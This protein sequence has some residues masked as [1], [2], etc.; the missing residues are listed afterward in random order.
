M[1]RTILI[2]AALLLTTMTSA[3]LSAQEI[4]DRVIQNAKV[5]TMDEANPNAQAVAMK[6]GKIIYVGDDAGVKA[7]VGDGTDVIDA[8]GTT[9]L[10]GFVSGHDHLVASGWTS[11]GVSLF[12][13]RKLDE[14]L[15]KI[16][17][18]ADTNPD[19]KIILGYGF[20]QVEFGGWPTKEDLDKIVPDRPVFILDFTIHDVWMNSMAFKA[21]N[22]APDDPDQV[23]GVM[24]WQRNDKG[25][26]TGIGIEFQWAPAFIAAGAW[27]PE[28]EIPPFQKKFY[29]AAAKTGMT[30]VHVPLIA[31]PS[32]TN[33]KLS[34]KEHETALAILHELEKKGELKLRTFVANGFKDPVG[35]PKEIAE[36]TAMLREKYNSDMLQVWGIKIH[37]EGNWSSKTAWMLENYSDGSNTR[38]GAAIR[39]FKIMEMYLQANKLGLPVGTHVD[40]SQTVRFTIDAILASRIAGFDVPNNLLHHYFWVTD[41]DHKRTLDN[42]I[43][44][45]TTPIFSV[46][47]EGQDKN[48]LALMG[49]ERVNREFGRYTEL[50]AAGQNVSISS[51][52][53]SAPIDM[54]APLL[55]VEVAMTL[56]D[57]DNPDSK[58]F[59]TVRKPADLET[60]LKAVTIFPAQQQNMADKIG[61]ITVGKYADIAVLDKDITKVAPRDIG[62]IKV[63]GT[64]LNGEFT[65]R[66]GL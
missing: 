32:V 28:N 8:G 43:M 41:E 34:A 56:Q 19:K 45:N 5:K 48:A 52:V 23:P 17:E 30:A 7:H 47:W 25:E 9:V 55:N 29:D 37:P 27:D 14:A 63:R 33:Q 46:D 12:G 57:P 49:E 50:M 20:N 40:G 66:E 51:D 3:Q 4:A 38:G 35:N 16:K 31:A 60:A 36:H 6:D 53:P 21:G 10:P 54:V 26:Q 18:Y 65:H 24:F 1:N 22:V 62:E 59:P 39:G 61:T 64:L 58:P 15:A 2:F 13:V 44:V 42:N 11:R